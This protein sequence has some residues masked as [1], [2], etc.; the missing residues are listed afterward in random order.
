MPAIEELFSLAAE[1]GAPAALLGPDLRLQRVTR[2]AARLLESSR[3]ALI[4][5]PLR[6]ALPV[7]VR[8][9][10]LSTLHHKSV[11]PL[12]TASQ[13]VMLI[14]PPTGRHFLL[15]A[16]HDVGTGETAGSLLLTCREVGPERDPHRAVT[17]ARAA[18]L[19]TEERF[20]FTLKTA[21]MRA[22]EWDIL[23]DRLAC[24][25]SLSSAPQE[26]LSLAPQ[27][28]TIAQFITTIHP[29][30]RDQFRQETEQAIKQGGTDAYNTSYRTW[31]EPE[32]YRWVSSLGRVTRNALGQ[33]V[34]VAGIT[35]DITSR[36][37]T[38]EQMVWQASHDTL[39]SLPNR[40]HFL[41]RVRDAVAHADSHVDT[42]P[43]QQESLAVLFVDLDGFKRINDTLGHSTG[44]AVLQIAAERLRRHVPEGSTLGR[45]GGDEF[46]VL[47]PPIQTEQAAVQAAEEILFALAQPFQIG[48]HDLYLSASVGISI[49]P[50][51]GWD[52]ETLIRHADVAMYHAKERG[53]NHYQIHNEEMNR[54]AFD[55]LLLENDLRRALQGGEMA[56]VYQPQIALNTGPYAAAAF[57]TPASDRR[58]A[59]AEALMRWNHPE[60]GSV[61][62]NRFIPLAEET[63]IIR[64]L[65]QWIVY[66][67]CH[68]AREWERTGHP[69]RVAVNLSA[70]QLGHPGIIE[71]VAQ[72]LQE[73]KLNPDMLELEIT[74]S[75]LIWNGEA[76]VET[77][78]RLKDLGVR[79][80]VDDFGTGYSSLS[81][82]RRFPLDAVKIDRSFIMELTQDLQAR[83]I[84]R[85]VIDL[86]HALSLWVVA[87]GVETEAQRDLLAGLGCDLMQGYLFSRAVSAPRL[88]TLLEAG[89]SGV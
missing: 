44:D 40:L 76:A 32:G 73:T 49:Y 69:V 33:A 55:R 4:G 36:K 8:D 24:Y 87:E 70:R 28:Q 48:G 16:H 21:G 11:T 51:D 79:L 65:G 66:Q 7:S 6:D 10:V 74:E 3:R 2:A 81:Y 54:A 27:I 37:E 38:E 50:Y 83:A 15:F 1:T 61:P 34:R 30:D 9:T 14:H 42:D 5:L 45:Q 80:C 77:A 59:A 47:L 56:V 17:R 52:A 58:I 60:I 68:Q 43:E 23:Q 39:T 53:R 75:A 19:E 84:V 26:E 18:Q 20:Q 64:S 62:R 57:F 22:W 29:A 89:R 41:E 25:G 72:V 31:V 67:A 46:T 13:K 35:R 82:L 78:F 63:G 86:A 12:G 88:T 71:T 85:A